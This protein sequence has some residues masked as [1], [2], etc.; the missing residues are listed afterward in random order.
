MLENGAAS[1][2]FSSTQYVQE[3][4]NNVEQY[5][6]KRGEKLLAKATAPMSKGYRPEI[7]MSEELG[8]DESSYYQSLIG[9]LRWIVELGRV[10]ICT[11]VS[12]MSS[13]LALPRQGHL[14]E[15]FHIFAYLRSRRRTQKWS[16]IQQ[17]LRLTSLSFQDKTG[18]TPSMGMMT[19]R[20]NYLPT[21][22][23]LL[24]EA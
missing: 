7:D 19:C 13:H 8:E 6:L 5:L 15:L 4:V 3:A 2:A 11:E 23:C 20:R 1:W 17:K 24:E 16:M 10:D 21:C 12:M 9:V 18:A 22:L 14:K